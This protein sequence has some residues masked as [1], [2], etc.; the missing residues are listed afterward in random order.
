MPSG[1]K[2]YV[3]TI[4]NPTDDDEQALGDFSE[5]PLVQYLVFGREQ[6]E[7]GTPHLQGYVMLHAPKSRRWLSGILSRAYI[8]VSR[9]TP[10]QASEY[11]KKE[12]DF[13]EFGEVPAVSQGKRTD[14]E[15][16]TEWAKDQERRPP[17]H[18]VIRLFPGLWV[19]Y[20]RRLMEIIDANMTQPRLTEGEPRDWQIDLA[21]S[22][23][24]EG[25]NRTI[26]FYVD[27]E[28]GK[29]KT[30]FCNY[31]FDE[32]PNDVQY[33][34]VGKRDDL[35]HALDETKRI[36][37]FDIPRGQM[38]YL[39]YSILEQI[40]DRMV[41]SPKYSSMTKVLGSK[42]HVVVFSNE[43]PDMDKLTADRYN[44]VDI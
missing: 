42:T 15:R 41:F 22:L 4:N 40:K 5:D 29:G 38:E 1:A 30:W 35:A 17:V 13:E 24:E 36:F 16:F 6:G 27:A 37:L 32:F 11:C 23:R 9:G 19:R 20:S 18:E 44:V 33:L 2:R 8:E 43:H 34:R 25:D 26:N 10:F 31:M 39:Q 21:D 7:Q 14:I 28:G 12:G 3:F